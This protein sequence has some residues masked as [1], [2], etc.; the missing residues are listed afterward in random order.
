M[1]TPNKLCVFT[2]HNWI[3]FECINCGLKITATEKQTSMPIL[4]CRDI[5]HKNNKS[6]DEFIDQ[7][8]DWF[9]DKPDLA[10]KETVRNRLNICEGCE[11]FKN[12]TCT[13]CGCLMMRNKNFVGK[14]L[15][16]D[17]SCP[18]SKW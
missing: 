4:P 17:A 8:L 6:Q 13:K 2:T 10:D 14:V 9:K 11:F 5:L 7:M 18:E 15:K 12:D 1:E 16:K 3:D